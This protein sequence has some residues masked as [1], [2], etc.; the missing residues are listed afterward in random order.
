MEPFSK[1]NNYHTNHDRVNLHVIANNLLYN[2]CMLVI[3]YMWYFDINWVRF[4]V[5]IYFIFIINELTS[6]D[7]T[8]D[9]MCIIII[10]STVRVLNNSLI[11]TVAFTTRVLPS[12]SIYTMVSKLIKHLLRI[13]HH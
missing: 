5:L 11:F 9:F 6:V 8:F 1:D 3:L 7:K 4:Y 13:L 12:I 2:T 10:I